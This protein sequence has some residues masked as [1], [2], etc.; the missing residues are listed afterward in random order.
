MAKLSN[1]QLSFLKAHEISV[2]QMFDASGMRRSE[3]R[4]HMKAIGKDFAYGVTECRAAGHTLRSRKGHCIQCHPAVISFTLRQDR[5]AWV[6]IAGSKSLKIV[7]I[8]HSATPEKRIYDGNCA[9]YGGASDW[10]LLEKVLVDKAPEIEQDVQARLL[11]YALPGAYFMGDKLTTSRECFACG[12]PEAW[13][14]L[15]GALLDR[16]LLEVGL[17]NPEGYDF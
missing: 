2:G 1:E 7:K 9:G 8:G 17:P 6:Y 10:C 15:V 12:Y 14:A 4:A 13:N 16:G 5:T 3:Y 11:E